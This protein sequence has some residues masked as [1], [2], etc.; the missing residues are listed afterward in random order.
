[1]SPATS[2]YEP[3]MTMLLASEDGRAWTCSGT[4]TGLHPACQAEACPA[5]WVDQ[6]EQHQRSRT[7]PKSAAVHQA[8]SDCVLQVATIDVEAC[9]SQFQ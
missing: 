3:R 8:H 6:D 2:W 4:L 5:L 9:N 7:R 1:M